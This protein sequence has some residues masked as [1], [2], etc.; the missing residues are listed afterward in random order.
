MA[1]TQH[2][3]QDSHSNLYAGQHQKAP[4]AQ[5]HI[6]VLQVQMLDDS[7]EFSAKP[8]ATQPYGQAVKQS[9]RYAEIGQSPSES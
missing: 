8:L 2:T 9:E 7:T 1:S 6:K 4:S 5:D 3:Q